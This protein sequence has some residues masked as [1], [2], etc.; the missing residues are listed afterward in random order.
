MQLSEQWVLVTGGARGLGESITR[1]LA[2][3]STT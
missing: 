3:S 1:A 2:W